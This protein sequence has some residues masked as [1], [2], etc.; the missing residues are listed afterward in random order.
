MVEL[1]NFI[2]ITNQRVLLERL[3]ELSTEELMTLDKEARSNV[4]LDKMTDLRRTFVNIQDTTLYYRT[5]EIV[6]AR[7]GKEYYLNEHGLTGKPRNLR[8]RLSL[9]Y[10]F[11]GFMPLVSEKSFEYKG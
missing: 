10:L 8:E 1:N 6:I 5:K 3:V 11:L 9:S 7:E 4:S 2:G